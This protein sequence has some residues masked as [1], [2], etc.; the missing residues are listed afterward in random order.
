MS[1]LLRDDLYGMVEVDVVLVVN[2]GFA[3][4]SVDVHHIMGA[5]EGDRV[6]ECTARMLYG[7]TVL[8]VIPIVVNVPLSFSI[9]KYDTELINKISLKWRWLDLL[10]QLSCFTEQNADSVLLICPS[11]RMDLLN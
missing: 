1:V 4:D 9:C 5:C 3:G 10:D 11:S 6:L 2:I 8:S 7:A